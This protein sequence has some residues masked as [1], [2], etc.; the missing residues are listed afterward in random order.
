MRGTFSPAQCT[1]SNV[2]IPRLQGHPLSTPH[3]LPPTVTKLAVAAVAV[4]TLAGLA[5]CSTGSDAGT[6]ATT[7]AAASFDQALFDELPAANQESKS[8]SFGALWENPPM[9]NV[10]VDDS[11][12]PIGLAPELAAALSDVLGVTPEWQN[13]QWPAQLPGVQ[14]GNVDALLG[15]VSVTAEREVGVVDLIPF[16][17]GT[18]SI[19]VPAGNPEDL[20]SLASGCGLTLGGGVGSTVSAMITAASD[21][22]VAEGEPAISVAE[23][24]NAQ[25]AVSAVQAGTIDGWVDGTAN[26]LAAVEALP[27][28]FASVEIPVAESEVADPGL[29][30]IAVA[31]SNPELSTALADALKA[32]IEN[33]TYEEILAGY[34]LES[35]ALTADEVVINPL[36]GTPVGE[37]E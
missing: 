27:D 16:Y 21:A 1:V 18:Y 25:N 29:L 32:I 13:L 3:L 36:S 35:S 31:K 28:A 8:V 7:E 33:G 11:T 15:Q 19:L 20:D 34:G 12:V 10:S 37:T 6:P 14:S 24:P 30:G 5:A 23:Y 17:R 4:A 22:C 9:V 2:F 26:Q